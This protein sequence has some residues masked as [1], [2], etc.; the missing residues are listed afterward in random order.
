MPSAFR[1]IL[2]IKSKF[3]FLFNGTEN[4]ALCTLTQWTI[5]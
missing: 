1:V 4:F 5:Y 2:P 3:F